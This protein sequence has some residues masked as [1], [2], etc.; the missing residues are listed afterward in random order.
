MCQTVKAYKDEDFEVDMFHKFL[1]GEYP[2]KSFFWYVRTSQL[3][4]Q[5]PKGESVPETIDVTCIP[6]TSNRRSVLSTLVTKKKQDSN[7]EEAKGNS[8][9]LPKAIAVLCGLC[10]K[11]FI[12]PYEIF[13]D[14]ACVKK[15]RREVKEKKAEEFIIRKF[16]LQEGGNEKEDSVQLVEFMGFLRGCKYS[17]P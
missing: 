14:W 16:H 3:T 4:V 11:G 12:K 7:K 6:F 2:L 10:D 15:D 8:I 17:N 9:T 1:F 5:S 13:G